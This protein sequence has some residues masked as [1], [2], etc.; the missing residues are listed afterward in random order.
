MATSTERQDPFDGIM[1]AAHIDVLFDGGS[2]VNE[3]DVIVSNRLD[4]ETYKALNLPGR[5]S[6]YPEKSLEY[7]ERHRSMV[8]EDYGAKAGLAFSFNSLKN[9]GL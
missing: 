3:D 8:F 9:N 1:L 2:F 6:P 4:Y 5:I 7:L